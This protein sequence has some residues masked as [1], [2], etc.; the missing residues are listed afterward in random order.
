MKF[1]KEFCW[2]NVR[3]HFVGVWCV[4]S[5][6]MTFV[7]RILTLTRDTVSSLGLVKKDV[8]ITSSATVTNACHFRHAFALDERRVKFLPECFVEVSAHRGSI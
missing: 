7:P 6:I 3:I 5:L 2:Q 1:R 4:E 8:H